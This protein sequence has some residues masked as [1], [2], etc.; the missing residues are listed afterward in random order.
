MTAAAVRGRR[1]RGVARGRGGGHGRGRGRGRGQAAADVVVEPG[2]HKTAHVDA[3]NIEPFNH[4]TGPAT[5]LPP[6]TEPIRFFEQVFD[7]FVS[8]A[9]ATN[10]NAVAKAPPRGYGPHHQFNTGDPLWHPTTADEVK[11]YIGINIAM[12]I[13]NLPGYKDYW[14]TEP[15][16][17]DAFISGILMR[18]R[19]EKLCQYLH[20]SVPANEDKNYKLTKVSPLI[21]LCEQNFGQCYQ[22]SRDVSIDE[23]MVQFDG[24]LCWKQYTPKK[25]VKWG[26][27]LWCLCDSTTGCCAA[28]SVYCGRDDDQDASFDLGYK[29]VMRLMLDRLQHHHHVYADNVFLRSTWL[30]PSCGPAHTCVARHARRGVTSRRA[31]SG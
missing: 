19:Y 9:E 2:W 4:T 24:R 31:W 28:L 14:S 29:V 13:K 11:A 30:R 16:L 3:P 7:F 25:P 10:L 26:I 5:L 18:T 21:T 23:A 8:V 17:H 1:T 15:L 20:C 22:P 12:G 27:K 6:G